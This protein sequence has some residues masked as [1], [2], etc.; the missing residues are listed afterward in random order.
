MVTEHHVI[1]AA[2]VM[3]YYII[4]KKGYST[5]STLNVQYVAGYAPKAMGMTR[6]TLTLKL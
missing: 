3:A 4:Y 6:V 2:I 5:R 1:A